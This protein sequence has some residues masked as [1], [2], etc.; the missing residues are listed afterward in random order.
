[1][2]RFE[3]FRIMLKETIFWNNSL[4]DWLISLLII[5]GGFLLGRFIFFISSKILSKITAKTPSR[6]DDIIVENFKSPFI[7]AI[8]TIS[9]WVALRRL[10]FSD[11]IDTA[12]GKIYTILIILNVTWAVAKFVKTLLQEYLLPYSQREDTKL[13]SNM[14]LILNRV[15]TYSIWFIGIVITLHNIGVE[16]GTLIAGLGIGGAAIALA[17]QDSLKN[18]FGG[19][20]L[21]I[22]RPFKIGDR[23]KIGEI[24]GYVKDIGL[25]SLRIRTLDGR[26]ITIPNYQ[27]VDS[28]LE[29]VSSEPSRRIQIRLGLTYDTTP[30]KME[31]AMSILQNLPQQIKDIT[32]DVDVSF[33]EYGDFA[34]QILFIYKIR[35]DRDIFKTQSIVNLEILRQF[36]AN[37]L[38]F[39]FP[40]QTIYPKAVTN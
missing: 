25:R 20:T 1:M 30:E 4:A 39:A 17:A 22:D 13:D 18:L 19:I 14:L 26:A 35:K 15:L 12:L 9:V 2:R 28:T 10:H 7:L 37:G 33:I 8:I 11:S 29:N 32:K 40:T 24:D 6:L 16:I 38:E 36:N 21:Y 5:I 23:I 31:L 27:V 34:L 3:I